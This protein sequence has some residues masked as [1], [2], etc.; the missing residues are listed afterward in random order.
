MGIGVFVKH[1]DKKYMDIMKK[2]AS[3]QKLYLIMRHR[4]IFM[5]LIINFVIGY[6]SKDLNNMTQEKMI[7]AFG[8]QEEVVVKVIIY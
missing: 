8:R 6:L 3:E 2:L 1:P 7:Q 5:E 4:I